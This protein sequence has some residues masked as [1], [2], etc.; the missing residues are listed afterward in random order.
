MIKKSKE[1]KKRITLF[2]KIWKSIIALA[3]LLGIISPTNI[4]I[5]WWLIVILVA[6]VVVLAFYWHLIENI[7]NTIDKTKKFFIDLR[8]DIKFIK[9]NINNKAEGKNGESK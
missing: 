7:L 8:K 2:A 3:V 4:T 9:D 5:N 1:K 6:V